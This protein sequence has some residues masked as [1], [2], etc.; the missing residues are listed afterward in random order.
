MKFEILPVLN[1]MVDL[2]RY[3]RDINRF[4]IYMNLLQGNTPGNLAVPISGFN[5]MAKPHVLDRLMLL[6]E[7]KAEEIMKDLLEQLNQTL[8]NEERIFQVVFTLADDLQGGWTNR[9]SMDYDSKFKLNGMLS[10]NFCTPLFW[11]SETID[12]TV[13]KQR[14]LAYCYRT[15]Y[16][17]LDAQPQ[18]LEEHMRQEWFVCAKSGGKKTSIPDI[19]SLYLFIGRLSKKLLIR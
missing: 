14:T 12:E 1:K 7:M 10:R 19:T 4:K 15:I 9:H 2:Y 5:P 11:T 6:E 16:R 17:T 3:P 13:I 18:S 8:N